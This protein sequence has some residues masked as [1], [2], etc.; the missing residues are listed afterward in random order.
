MAAHALQQS[1]GAEIPKDDGSRIVCGRE[2]FSAGAAGQCRHVGCVACKHA[3]RVA[4]ADG[5]H[6]DHFVAAAGEDVGA[7]WVESDGVNVE[8]MA[9]EHA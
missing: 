2:D 3:H 9:D 8:V 1:P 6:A 7:V 4:V 5:P